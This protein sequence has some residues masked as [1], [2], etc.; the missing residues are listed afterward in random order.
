MFKNELDS[1]FNLF[2][3]QDPQDLQDFFLSQFPEETEK[4]IQLIL[5][6]LSKNKNKIESIPRLYFKPQI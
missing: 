5:W 1:Y 3:G 4:N 6:I 2:L